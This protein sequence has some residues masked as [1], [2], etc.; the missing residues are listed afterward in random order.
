MYVYTYIYIYI[1]THTHVR[2]TSAFP[3]GVK[4][5]TELLRTAQREHRYQH[6]PGGRLVSKRVN[7]PLL[8]PNQ[9]SANYYERIG[10]HIHSNQ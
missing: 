5:E 3:E 8:G 7:A 10:T 2:E 1:Y 4:E 6:L 9:P